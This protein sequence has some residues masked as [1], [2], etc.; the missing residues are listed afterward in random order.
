M[1][2]SKKQQAAVLAAALVLVAAGGTAAFLLTGKDSPKPESSLSAENSAT[3]ASQTAAEQKAPV[4]EGVYHEQE[5]Q[6]GG[7]FG[8]TF[9]DFQ[10][11]IVWFKDSENG[12]AFVNQDGAIVM[13]IPKTPPSNYTGMD[14]HGN[15][16]KAFLDKSTYFVT[17]NRYDQAGEIDRTAE[18]KELHKPGEEQYLH[19]RKILAD[20]SYLY[21]LGAI[22]GKNDSYLQVYDWEG[23]SMTG[24]VI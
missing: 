16:L 4:P 13:E 7:Y 12:S 8:D 22:Q 19:I 1:K 14:F 5:A 11:E 6:E 15:I 10:G 17:V 3:E 24:K 18:L 2:L 20:D 21:V 9:C 23:R